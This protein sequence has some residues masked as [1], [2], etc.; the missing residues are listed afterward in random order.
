M[1]IIG[2]VLR[3]NVEKAIDDAKAQG[4]DTATIK[5]GALEKLWEN[6]RLRGSAL[7]PFGMAARSLSPSEPDTA[8]VA[9][10][11]TYGDLRAARAALDE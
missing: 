8:P 6:Y 4:S 2:A 9:P 10:R 1:G 11:V 3:V 5:L 7:E